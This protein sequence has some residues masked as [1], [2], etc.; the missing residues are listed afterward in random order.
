M[1]PIV[2]TSISVFFLS[3][4]ALALYNTHGDNT[5]LIAEAE[6]LACQGRCIKLVG[7]ERTPI[8]QAFTF[9]TSLERQTTVHVTCRRTFYLLGPYQCQVGSEAIAR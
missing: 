3:A 5:E 7:M 6:T 8:G 2:R 4:T 9:Q 1:N